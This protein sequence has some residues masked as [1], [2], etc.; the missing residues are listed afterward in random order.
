ML[1]PQRVKLDA[2]NIG[3]L[4]RTGQK[5]DMDKVKMFLQT[6]D[7][8]CVNVRR[9]ADTPVNELHV[10][11][12]QRFGLEGNMNLQMYARQQRQINGYPLRSFSANAPA[13]ILPPKYGGFPQ[14]TQNESER[15][16]YV[17]RFTE[18]I[19]APLQQN[20]L[21]LGREGYTVDNFSA[22]DPFTP[23]GFEM[24]LHKSKDAIDANEYQHALKRY[25]ER[26]EN[27]RVAMSG[28]KSKRTKGPPIGVNDGVFIGSDGRIMTQVASVN[29]AAYMTSNAFSNYNSKVNSMLQQQGPPDQNDRIMRNIPSNRAPEPFVN[30][31]MLE[32]NANLISLVPQN[33]GVRN[34]DLIQNNAFLTP[35]FSR[36]PI[37]GMQAGSLLGSSGSSTSSQST[38]SIGNLFATP[39]EIQFADP[40]ATQYMGRISA[41]DRRLLRAAQ[42]NQPKP[43]RRG[44]RNRIQTSRFSPA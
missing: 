40:R 11:G 16:D 43:A 3:F 5:V 8:G 2:A 18:P 23:M 31:D 34:S 13:V 44:S 22:S 21:L 19:S 41:A 15:T 37:T 29:D 7:S 26:T 6:D 27:R 17:S 28:G 14:Y 9:E 38:I 25:L 35:A 42:A 39:E 24:N 30:M 1:D 12:G 32:D 10:M 33:P 36:A 4:V 20:T